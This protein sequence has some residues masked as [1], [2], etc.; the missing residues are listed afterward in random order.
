MFSGVPQKT[1]PVYKWKDWQ[2]WNIE[3]TEVTEEGTYIIECSANNKPIRSF[4]FHIQNNLLERNTISNVIYYFKGQRCSGL[5][6]KAD[7]NMKFD[8]LE[9][10]TVDVHGGWYDA[11]GDYG[12]HLSH[13]TFSTYFNPQQTPLTVWSLFKS[14]E[15]L[16]ERG[17]PNFTQ[18]KRRL[19]DE[20]MYGADY[21][22]RV[23]NPKGSFYRTVS[24][25][26][27]KKAP[28]D[29]CISP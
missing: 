19:L 11:T 18:Y 7:R 12:K 2:F 22:V 6:D 27:P 9:G 8:G 17:D 15:V 28:E 24:G 1:G 3:F 10:K 25:R 16:A 14:Y 5:L 4:P 26:G 23:K 29:R 20:A 13:L 21:L